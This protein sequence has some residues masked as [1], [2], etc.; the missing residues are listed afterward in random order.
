MKSS[1]LPR[2]V[3]PAIA[4]VIAAVVVLGLSASC[5]SSE[6]RGVTNAQPG[7]PL[8]PGQCLSK[9]TACTLNKDCC[10]QFCANG[11]CVTNQP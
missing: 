7:T 8:A 6:Q 2:L 9:G 3:V 1:R 11:Q 4:H 5:G 10:S